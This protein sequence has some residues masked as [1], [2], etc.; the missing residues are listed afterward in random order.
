MSEGCTEE[1]LKKDGRR[2]EEEWK[3]NG[4]WQKGCRGIVKYEIIRLGS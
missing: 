2:M 3:K 1:G 4:K